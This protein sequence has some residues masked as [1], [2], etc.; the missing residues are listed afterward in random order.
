VLYVCIFHER[1]L[2]SC[3]FTSDVISLLYQADVDIAKQLAK[4]I[5]NGDIFDAQE[6]Y[7]EEAEVSSLLVLD[8][9]EVLGKDIKPVGLETLLI[10]S[11]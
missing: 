11:P 4:K 2:A 7:D 3:P 10:S 5:I 8:D 9:F 6:Y 1:L